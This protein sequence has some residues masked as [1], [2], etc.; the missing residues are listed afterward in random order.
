MKLGKTDESNP[1]HWF[2]F[3]AER[4]LG[5]DVLSQHEG[6]APSSVEALQ[7]AAERYLKGFLIAN[8][9]ALKRTHDLKVLV[10]DAA[11]HVPEFGRFLDLAE[12]LTAE[13]FEQHYPGGDLTHVG[14]HYPDMRAEAGELVALIERSLPGYFPESQAGGA[15]AAQ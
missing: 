4:L 13:F 5:A 8:G 11:T 9:W 7:E 2:A 3:A 12:R 15:T 6:T 1:A 14:E 10:K